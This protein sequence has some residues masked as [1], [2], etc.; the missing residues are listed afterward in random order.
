M[1]RVWL[2]VT[3]ITKVLCPLLGTPIG[4]YLP[5]RGKWS[6]RG[7]QIPARQFPDNQFSI[8]AQDIIF[9]KKETKYLANRRW[10]P[11]WARVW[12]RRVLID[13]TQQRP[14]VW[15]LFLVCR[16]SSS[17][18][19]K[20]EILNLLCFRVI[21]KMKNCL[22]Q[23]TTDDSDFCIFYSSQK[24]LAFSDQPFLSQGTSFNRQR[25]CR[26]TKYERIWEAAKQPFI[27][28]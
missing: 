4:Q 17:C 2:V 23:C 9:Q 26:A 7:M 3:I 15:S 1:L 14:G 8:Q 27:S 6:I 12:L 13:S 20:Q 22:I 18:C 10:E 21:F 5:I 19:C 16:S 11:L 24:E 28:R 25:S